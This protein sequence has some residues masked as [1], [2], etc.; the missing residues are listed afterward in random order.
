MTRHYE[1]LDSLRGL[2]AFTV[3]F[4]HF[5]GA[6]PE[7]MPWMW[8]F[9]DNALGT[10]WNAF[11]GVTPH[12]APLLEM[13]VGVPMV[14]LRASSE[15]II[16]FFL[17]SGFVLSLSFVNGKKP[18]YLPYLVKR[19][20][21][22]YPAFL[23]AITAAFL[24]KLWLLNGP[25]AGY[26]DA[27]INKHWCQPPTWKVFCDHLP[28]I[29]R[30]STS[31]LNPPVWSMVVEMRISIIFPLLMLLFLKFRSKA[32]A[33]LILLAL[34]CDAWFF[35][36]KQGKGNKDLVSL[37]QTA[38]NI[39]FFLMG[40]WLANHRLRLVAWVQSLTPLQRRGLVATALILYKN[41]LW[42]SSHWLAGLGG[43]IPGISESWPTGLGIGLLHLTSAIG[44]SILLV[45]AISV[46]SFLCNKVVLFFGKISYS[47]YLC[48]M[49]TLY[50]CIALLHAYLPIWQVL[51]VALA[52]T[53]ALSTLSYY[54]VEAPTMRWG[55]ALS[56]SLARW[57]ERRRTPAP[58]VEA[59]L[60]E[61]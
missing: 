59:A 54:Y 26:S 43:H 10:V 35:V 18:A 19:V 41:D 27:W 4:C 36:L 12:G 53:I 29:N 7:S 9:G 52:S 23:A 42:I 50:A 47:L 3:I 44:A 1:E 6:Y 56:Q 60:K 39:G 2:G 58:C 15:A 57:M 30:F 28:L 24:V 16:F 38:S 21:R 5:L 49:V 61:P 40:A 20:F 32:V 37:L 22:L 13:L 14:L 34:C 31:Y 8:I 11:H 17:L 25:I 55:R 48:H 51:C 45:W 46:R 33:G